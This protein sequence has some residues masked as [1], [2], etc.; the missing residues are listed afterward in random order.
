M[1]SRCLNLTEQIFYFVVEGR[2]FTGFGK[3]AFSVMV[4][5]GEVVVTCW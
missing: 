3:N 1:P 5:D 4:F 2:F